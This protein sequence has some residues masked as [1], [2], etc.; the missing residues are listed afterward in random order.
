MALNDALAALSREWPARAKRLPP[1][2]LRY[3][4]EILARAVLTPT[5][6]GRLIVELLRAALSDDDLIWAELERRPTRFR[7]RPTREVAGALIDLRYVVESSLPVAD[8]DKIEEAA[9]ERLTVNPAASPS[10]FEP[11]PRAVVSRRA[12]R[13]A[14]GH[15]LCASLPVR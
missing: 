8:P 4:R 14:A 2:R 7:R 15:G 9:L 13:A 5:E 6:P 3:L 12:H 1:D 11:D 10:I